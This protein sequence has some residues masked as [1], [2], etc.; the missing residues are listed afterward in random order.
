[1][2]RDKRELEGEI[3][4]ERD[5]ER[6]REKERGRERERKRGREWVK[7]GEQIKNRRERRADQE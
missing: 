4:R 7:K 2:L 3:E 1:V 6:E 5:R